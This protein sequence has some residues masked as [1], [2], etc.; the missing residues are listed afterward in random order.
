MRELGC[1]V[2]RVWFPERLRRHGPEPGDIHHVLVGG[3]RPDDEHQHTICWSP[4]YHR[5]NLPTCWIRGE[6][7]QLTMD[8]AEQIYGPSWYHDKSAFEER[9]APESVL[10]EYQDRLIEAFGQA[11]A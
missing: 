3:Q 10:L 2:T 1:V 9:F 4:W 8:E 11:T 7:R 6:L 5:G